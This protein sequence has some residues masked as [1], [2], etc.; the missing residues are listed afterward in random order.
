M[1]RAVRKMLTKVRAWRKGQTMTDYALIMAA[2]VVVAS[3]SYV[4][5]GTELNKLVKSD[6]TVIKDIKLPKKG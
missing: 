2:V 5:F 4:K 1:M 6:Y 3:V